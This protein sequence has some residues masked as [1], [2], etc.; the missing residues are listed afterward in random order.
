MSLVETLELLFRPRQYGR[1][2][3]RLFHRREIV[4][5][6]ELRGR[7]PLDAILF[8]ETL[9]EMQDAYVSH[10]NLHVIGILKAD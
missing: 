5:S 10:L 1:G 7:D 8:C 2:E 6:L 3:Q 9:E 4:E